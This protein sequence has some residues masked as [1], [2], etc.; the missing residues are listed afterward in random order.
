MKYQKQD[1]VAIAK[2][3]FCIGG[4]DNMPEEI[5]Q[6]MNDLDV[7]EGCELEYFFTRDDGFHFVYHEGFELGFWVNPN[8]VEVK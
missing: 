7:V 8:L 1:K 3:L 4:N 6:T 2:G 5:E